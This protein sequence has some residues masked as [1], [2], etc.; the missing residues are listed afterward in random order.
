MHVA[1]RLVC[2]HSPPSLVINQHHPK[3]PVS[4]EEWKKVTRLK[5]VQTVPVSNEAVQAAINQGL[6]MAELSPRDPV[7]RAL[8]DWAS[9]LSP[10]SVKGPRRNWLAFLTGQT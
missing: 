9:A 3:N 7:V 5:E 8:H 1:R 4:V 6:P 2:R 10:E